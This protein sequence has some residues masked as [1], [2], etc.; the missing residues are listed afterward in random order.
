MAF[1]KGGIITLGMTI[2]LSGLGFLFNDPAQVYVNVFILIFCWLLI[3]FLIYKI[4]LYKIIGLLGLFIVI[5]VVDNYMEIPDNPIT[6]PLIILFW[7]GIAYLVLPEFFNKY[8]FAILVVYGLVL[9]Y[10]FIIRMMPNYMAYHRLN[11]INVILVPIPVFVTL[12][13]YEQW[14][15]LQTL[16]AEKAKSELTLL[17]H[18]INPHF[19]FNTLNNLY[20]LAIEKSAHTP[21]MILKLSDIMRYTI[22]DGKAEFVSLQKE[23]AYLEDYIEL[24]KIRYQ[25]K[26]EITFHKDLQHAHQIAPFLLIIPLENAFKHGVERQTEN[27]FI[28]L[29]LKTTPTSILFIV[30]NN[31]EPNKSERKGIGLTNL[32]KRLDLIYPNR[33]QLDITNTTNTFFVSIKIESDEL[34]D[35]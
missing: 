17:K 22:Y 15:W 14:R 12:W 16:K 25:R 13:I 2:V 8:K 10:F 34:S 35:H 1:I 18:Q 5:M 19:F 26:V 24:H 30:K 27:A 23:V 7:L 28:E 33:H 11:L 4:A 32:E 21:A 3:S 6:F 9:S 20:G 29:E 31:Y